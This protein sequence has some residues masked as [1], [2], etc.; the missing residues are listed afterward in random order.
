VL[1]YVFWH[2]PRLEVLS[3]DYESA[4]RQFHALLTTSPPSGFLGSTCHRVQ[5]APWAAGGGVAYEDWYLQQDSAALDALNTAAVS[6]A[7]KAAHDQAAAMAAGGTAGLY[8]LEL[9]SHLPAA[10]TALWFGKP[11]GWSYAMMADAMRPVIEMSGASL[12]MRRMVLGPTPEFCL[13]TQGPIPL[14]QGVTVQSIP[15]SMLWPT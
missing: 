14:P 1:S 10:T 15:L 6:A 13:R 8:Q 9:G 12:W 11:A 2:W 7:R 5:G 4:Q 3:D